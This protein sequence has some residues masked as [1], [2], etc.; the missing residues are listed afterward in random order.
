MCS[1]MWFIHAVTPD[2]AVKRPQVCIPANHGDLENL[3]S[4][5]ACP[6]S[7]TSVISGKEQGQRTVWS[8]VRRGAWLLVDLE[9][10]G[11]VM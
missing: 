1:R 4:E 10:L 9:V 11:E 5:R 3:L 7:H 2:S 6:D 8:G